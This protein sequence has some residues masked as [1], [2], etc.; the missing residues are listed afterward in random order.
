MANDVKAMYTINIANI[1]P[2]VSDAAVGSVDPV[3]FFSQRRH[4]R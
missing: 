2:V 1:F 3:C 4:E